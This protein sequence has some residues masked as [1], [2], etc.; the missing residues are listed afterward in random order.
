MITLYVAIENQVHA[1][2]IK[3]AAQLLLEPF[4]V[5]IR[6][7]TFSSQV[8]SDAVMISYGKTDPKFNCKF[9]LFIQESQFFE[10]YL[11]SRYLPRITSSKKQSVPVLYS[12]E[13]LVFNKKKSTLYTNQ[14]LIA[15]A[16]FWASRYKEICT[17]ERDQHN[18][19]HVENAVNYRHNLLS[20]PLVDEYSVMLKNWFMLNNITLPSSER[21]PDCDFIIC[22]SHDIDQVTRGRLECLYHEYRMLKT[23]PIIRLKNIAGLFA[24]AFYKR[25]VYWNFQEILDLERRHDANST[26]FFLSKSGDQPDVKYNFNSRAFRSVIKSIYNNGSQIGLHGSYHSAMEARS[27]HDEKIFIEKATGRPISSIRQHY[28]RLD[29]KDLWNRQEK[30]GFSIDTSLGYARRSGFRA[31]LARPFFPFNFKTQQPYSILEI[32]L[33]IMDGT[34]RHY[35]P[36]SPEKAWYDILPI[37]EKIKKHRGAAS[38]LWHNTFLVKYVK[39]QGWRELYEHILDWVNHNNGR[40]MSIE[41]AAEY[42]LNG[43]KP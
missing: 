36:K 30:A 43:R 12:P 27:L 40:N 10:N 8:P 9:N 15:S 7:V 1:S 26:F 32:P 21:Y 4:S 20:V 24:G 16:F 18:R 22:P 39:Y 19:F 38:I 14:D 3:Y 28:L 33:V 6:Y 42:W 17:D 34:Y 23:L 41:Q 29:V 11:Y 37:L 25:D 35:N 13:E 2:A 31:G 5:D